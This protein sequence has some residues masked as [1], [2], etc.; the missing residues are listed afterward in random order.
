MEEEIALAKFP[1]MGEVQ[2]VGEEG[3]ES[4]C[5][6]T[7]A[8]VA[9]HNRKGKKSGGFQSMGMCVYYLLRVLIMLYIVGFSHAVFTGI[10]KK[11]YRVPTPIQRK[12]LCT[13]SG[14]Q[15]YVQTSCTDFIS[16]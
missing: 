5:E 15:N 4:D 11:G 8:M 1:G 13:V 14:R 7:R 3:G 12:V 6:A 10:M 16:L 2:E 9:K